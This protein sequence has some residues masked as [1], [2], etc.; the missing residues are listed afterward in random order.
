MSKHTPGLTFSR[1]REANITRCLKWHPHGIQSWSASDWMTALVGEVGELASLLKMRN[2]ERDGLPGNKF[3]PT[4]KMVADEIADMQTYLDLLAASLGV[5]LGEA[6]IRKFNEVSERVGFPDRIELP[7]EQASEGGQAMTAHT[8]GPWVIY[9]E[10]DGTEICAVDRA[11][12][13]PIRQRIAHPI[14][15]KNWIANAR[16]VAAA[17]ELLE[18]L[19]DVLA[20]ERA[21]S[22]TPDTISGAEKQL[23]RIKEAVAKAEAAIAKATGEEV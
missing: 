3:S 11:P 14:I 10:T 16:L 22:R 9:P 20:A 5:D 23:D 4:D 17:P 8:P 18:A 6:T 15:G 2:R 21:G 13:L 7:T 19:R 1:F 12:G